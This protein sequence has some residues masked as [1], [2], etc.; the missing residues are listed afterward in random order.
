MGQYVIG[1]DQGTTSSRALV[2]D[3]QKSIVG[4]GQI[5]LKQI[6]QQS[7][8]VEHDPMEI[9]SASLAVARE[10]LSQA[11]IQ[12]G[13]VC[14]IG[15]T[16]Q[17]ETSLIWDRETGVPLYNAIVWQDRRTSDYCKALKLAGH[18]GLVRRKTG[19]LLDP[20]FSATKIKWMLDHTPRARQRAEAGELCFGTVDSWLIWNLTGG[21]AHVTDA[22]NASRTM[23]YNIVDGVWDDELLELFEVPRVMMP[24]VLDCMADFGLTDAG[25]FGAEVPIY[26]VAGDQHAAL[27]GQAC[28]KAGDM[29]S[30]YGTGCFSLMNI[31]EKVPAVLVGEGGHDD[32][33]SQSQLLVTL[34]YQ[35]NGKRFYALEGAIFIAGAAV[36]W[37]RDEVGLIDEAAECDELA[38][39]SDP[40]DPVCL[41]PAF[42][43]L[44]APYWQADVRGALFNL[45]RGTGRAEIARAALE[46]VGFQSRDLLLAMRQEM[47]EGSA[48]SEL[49]GLR[50]DGGL[51]RS[52]WTMQ[53][54][55]NML[56]CPVDRALVKETTAFGVAYLAGLH[57]GLYDGFDSFAKEWRSDKQFVP[58]RV[59]E[60]REIK[61]ARWLKA[62]R[63]L[64]NGETLG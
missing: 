59:S 61:Y 14:A 51:A 3:D 50:V 57:A 44:G 60:F 7:G 13:D 38:A 47:G 25:V 4:M 62:V 12:A 20:Y 49:A 15:I 35:I 42:A 40:D 21:K 11:G 34:G 37:L 52:D 48:D 19:L 43:G 53:F 16:N 46:A 33:Y 58:D 24:D 1:F 9:W 28:F 8:Y 30:T 10:A 39:R 17:R 41:V 56:D 6:Y 31:G 26:G 27:I 5:A 32:D 54:L 45:T 2:F 36:Q 29:K 64:I 18:E 23:L 55:A 22:T 63:T